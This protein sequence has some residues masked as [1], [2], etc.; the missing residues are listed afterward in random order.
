MEALNQRF[1]ALQDQ[2]MDIYEKGS[3]KLEDQIKHWNLLR[4]EQIM[5]HYSRK[6]GIMRLGYTPVPTLAVSEAKAKDAIFMVLQLEKLKASPYKNESWTLINT[7]LE[8]FRTPPAN[9]FKKGAQNVEVVFDGNP[10]NIMLYTAWQY[11]YFEDTDGQWQKTDGRI[12]YAGLYYMEGQL[13]HYYVDFKVDARRFGTR[14]EWEV[15]FNGE[16]IFA[17]VTS[18]SPSSFEEVR[19]RVEPPDVPE[20]GSATDSGTLHAG[21]PERTETAKGRRYERKESSPTAASLRGRQKVSGSTVR[22]TQARSRNYSADQAVA[23]GR[24]QR[25]TRARPRTRTRSRSRRRS[26]SSSR[27]RSRSRAR[28]RGGRSRGGYA[29]RS[30]SRSAESRCTDKCGIPASQV[31]TSVQSVGRKNTSRI[32]RLLDEALDPPVILLR[33]EP[34]ILKCYRYRVKDKHRGLFDKISTTWSWVGSQNS[35][36][37]GRARMLLSFISNDQRETFI[38]TMKLPK[39]V[40]WSYGSFASI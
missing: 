38:N 34:N 35:T 37:L 20:V 36:R 19:E 14:G 40:D 6:R 25:G 4:Q 28:E 29:T 18:S 17:P 16:T 3:D 15:R 32:E 21:R 13:K 8:T 5:L 39:N 10:E 30:R 9:C 12:D 33:G 31:G 24:G 11:I 2:L 1:S 26:R 7:S 27:S 22:K 23:R